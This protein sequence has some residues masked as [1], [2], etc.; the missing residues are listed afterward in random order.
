[1]IGTKERLNDYRILNEVG[2]GAFAT[3]HRAIH[4]PSG[5]IVALKIIQKPTPEPNERETNSI[6]REV[7][8]SMKADH[9]LIIHIFECFQ[10]DDHFYI[11]MEYIEGQSLFEIVTS[12]Q[13]LSEI[14][15][16]KYFQQII[17]AVEYLHTKIKVVHR[18]IKA[19]N[20]L[21]DKNDN[22]RLIDFGLSRICDENICQLCSTACGSPAY[23]AP[24][25][26]K[27]T[28]YGN[29]VD[30]WNCGIILYVMV[31]GSLPFFD[32]NISRQLQKILLTQPVYPD[33]ISPGLKCLISKMLQKNPEERI[34]LQQINENPWYLYGEK[35][36]DYGNPL[37]QVNMF[38]LNY[39]ACNEIKQKYPEANFERIINDSLFT[40][41]AEIPTISD[42][43]PD[44]YKDY[45]SEYVYYKI[46]RTYQVLDSV[47]EMKDMRNSFNRRRER[48][49]FAFNHASFQRGV[50]DM[51]K[52][53][54]IQNSPA[55]DATRSFTHKARIL[56][57][58]NPNPE[59]SFAHVKKLRSSSA[60]RS[61]VCI[62]N[63]TN[64]VSPNVVAKMTLT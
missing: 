13:K 42:V 3:V 32:E 30:I 46:V 12:E 23:A 7:E 15:A 56:H 54:P 44:L 63:R 59:M 62:L 51:Q 31:V 50:G 16:R 8:I 28:D 9:P 34:T 29:I 25:V 52:K 24:E 14:R 4:V 40:S 21:I 22:I 57:H 19:E 49:Q 47:K 61:P 64:I 45:M 37:L 6:K 17:Q 2:H 39:E 26:I 53:E 35:Q 36:M 18:D 60:K 55:T 33:T 58:K 20:I 5:N 10:D 11:S 41:K 1:M 27:K 48:N 38:P 43:N